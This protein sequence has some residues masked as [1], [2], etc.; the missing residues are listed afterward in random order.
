MQDNFIFTED[1]R[2]LFLYQYKKLAEALSDSITFSDRKQLRLLLSLGYD[3]GVFARGNTLYNPLNLLLGTC[4]IMV[5]ELSLK[6]RSTLSYLL[7]PLVLSNITSIDEINAIFNTDV[8]GI[9]KGLIKIHQLYEKRPVIQSEN[10]S[11]LLLTF[12]EDLRVVLIILA[13]KLYNLRV[14]MRNCDDDDLKIKFTNEAS[15]LYAPLSHRLGLYKVKSELEDL[16]LKYS[17]RKVYSDIAKK[18][19][20]TKKSRDEFIHSFIAPIEERLRPLNVKFE[21]KGRTKSIHSIYNKLRKQQIEFEKIYDL[22]AIRIIV[23]VPFDQEKIVCW[24]IYSII[25]DMYQPNPKRLKDWISIP[26]S[27]GYESLHITVLGPQKRWVE[28]QIRTQRMDEIAESGLAAHWKYK[29]GKSEKGMDEW[30][31]NMREI[32]VD[33]ESMTAGD[34]MQ[35]LKPESVNN[36]IY[37][38]TPKGDVYKLPKGATV[39]DF[40]FEIHTNLGCRCVGAK[41][42]SKIVNIRHELASGDQVDILTS[43]QQSPKQDWLKIVKTSRARV[44]IK[45]SFKEAENKLALYGKE[46]FYRRMKNRKIDVD[47]G[48]LMRLI[49]KEGYKMVNS[50]FAEIGKEKLDVNLMIDHYLDIDKKEKEI[51]TIDSKT[52][53]SFIPSAKYSIDDSFSK[54]DEI[55]IDRDL[56]GIDYKLAKCCNPVYGDDVFGFLSING[57]VKIHRTQCPNAHELFSRFGYRIL[58]A[59]WT[60][61]SGSSYPITL[62]VIGNDDIGIVTNITSII[63]KE[64]NITLRSISIDTHAGLFEGQ[65]TVMVQDL[66]SL[67]NLIK[68]IQTIKGVKSVSRTVA[69]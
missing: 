17:N 14:V 29:G 68:K 19:A 45:Q 18:L 44:K 63:N 5:T 56:K 50:F 43:P 46:L 59:K 69:N 3:R 48:V 53:E 11:K 40:A 58:K 39:L 8:S 65:M 49:K 23:D 10:F 42:G 54:E 16:A 66:V 41:I 32:L 20:E 67:D 33:A 27:N 47:E 12:S 28:V 4:L 26:K 2:K 9:L 52:A 55:I 1:E 36:E 51:T 38:F 13:E 22:F 57:G 30:L 31:K 21:I 35:D 7:Y 34:I 6:R 37:V 25:T 15:Y 24:N 61:K 60:G 62:Y 64:K